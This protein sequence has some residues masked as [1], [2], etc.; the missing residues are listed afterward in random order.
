MSKLT[1]GELQARSEELGVSSWT[2]SRIYKIGAGWSLV[3][4][5][6]D[7]ESIAVR[8]FSIEDAVKKAIE[9][10]K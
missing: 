1:L 8:G 5:M 9:E 2:V 7:G 10:I 6:S 4:I 3:A